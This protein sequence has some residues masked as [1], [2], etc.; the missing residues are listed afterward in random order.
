VSKVAGQRK[1]RRKGTKTAGHLALR[2][3]SISRFTKNVEFVANVSSLMKKIR[4]ARKSGNDAIER[5]AF[6]RLQ[7]IVGQ[8]SPS[9]RRDFNKAMKKYETY[10]TE[11]N[12]RKQLAIRTRQLI[13][14]YGEKAT[15]VHLMC[16]RHPGDYVT[17]FV[18]Q[19]GPEQTF[20]AIVKRHPHEFPEYVY[21]IA[22]DRLKTF[23]RNRSKE[24]VVAET[25]TV[26]DSSSSV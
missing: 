17:Q 24:M 6:E 10:L 3:Q 2:T 20:E 9:I 21:R 26:G 13:D 22:V 19:H 16:N 5:R 12:S 11:K 15:L 4:D 7:E 18:E 8:L 1:R 14:K 25:L 23:K